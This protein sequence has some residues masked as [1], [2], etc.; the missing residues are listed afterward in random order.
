MRWPKRISVNEFGAWFPMSL[1]D[2]NRE[3]VYVLAE[4]PKKRKRRKAKKS[5]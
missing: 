1:H 4:T 3:R 5:K 2:P